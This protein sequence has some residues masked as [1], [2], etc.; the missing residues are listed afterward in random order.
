MT[1]KP[2]DDLKAMLGNGVFLDPD[3]RRIAELQ[4]QTL[5]AERQDK[6]ARQVNILTAALV[7]IAIAEAILHSIEIWSN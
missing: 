2:I 1:K 5:L 6:T 4:L 3:A 7:L